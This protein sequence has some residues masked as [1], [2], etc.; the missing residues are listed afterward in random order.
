ML[1][2]SIMIRPVKFNENENKIESQNET[3]EATYM[4]VLR[5]ALTDSPAFISTFD[6]VFNELDSPDNHA[7]C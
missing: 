6:L 4:G 3:G 5:A 1:A 2:P 7:K